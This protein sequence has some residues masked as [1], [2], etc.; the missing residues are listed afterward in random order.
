MYSQNTN[1]SFTTNYTYPVPTEY[2]TPYPLFTTTFYGTSR[3][4]SVTEP[5]YRSTIYSNPTTYPGF[6]TPTAYPTSNPTTKPTSFSGCFYYDVNGNQTGSD[7]L[8]PAG[9]VN[10]APCPYV[11]TT[12]TASVYTYFNTTR[13]TE[14][15]TTFLT[16]VYVAQSTFSIFYTPGRTDP[17]NGIFGC[18]DANDPDVFAYCQGVGTCEGCDYFNSTTFNTDVGYD[19]ATSAPA[20]VITTFQT[21]ALTSV[22]YLSSRCFPSCAYNCTVTTSYF[23]FIPTFYAPDTVV[24]SYPINTFVRNTTFEIIT[25]FTTSN[26]TF[27]GGYQPLNTLYVTQYPTSNVTSNLT[28]TSYIVNTTNPY[29]V[30]TA[31]LTSTSF[32]TSFSTDYVTNN[33]TLY[34]TNMPITFQTSHPTS[35]PTSIFT[36][37]ATELGITSHPTTIQ[38]IFNTSNLTDITTT[39]DT[40]SPTTFTTLVSTSNDTSRSTSRITEWL[41]TY[42]QNTEVLTSRSTTWFTQ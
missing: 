22:S 17:V 13:S 4:T 39:F 5:V 12:G 27:T 2:I 28:T 32:I 37:R 29:N 23:T 33:P 15:T 14:G 25:N 20:T 16:H 30:P 10:P 8:P 40:S 31:Y 7:P 11:D 6:T 24:T 21:S 34:V 18:Y 36:A 42:P 38:A 3:P 35:H 41:T 1:T 26:E 19:T 9:C